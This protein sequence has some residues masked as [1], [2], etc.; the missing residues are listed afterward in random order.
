M[1]IPQSNRVTDEKHVTDFIRQNSFGILISC[2]EGAPF[3]THLP[4]EYVES[5]NGDKFLHGHLAR[6]N[7]QWRAFDP[8]TEVLAIFSGPHTYVSAKWY[9]HVN[10]PTW[11]YMIAHVY[12]KPRVIEKFD[13]LHGLLKRLVDKHEAAINPESPYTV[14]ALPQEYLQAQ[15]KGI[16]GFE[17]KI[18]RIEGK[19]KLSQNRE[20]EDF[21][22]VIA[23]LRAS[24]EANAQQVAEAMARIQPELFE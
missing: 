22:N 7:Q 15:M 13:E 17:I 2:I 21:L 5:A 14:E 4:L 24:G 18:T 16:V 11:N 20:Q 3:A 6:G 9:N 8:N 1:Y 10:V 23:K 12:G 19:F